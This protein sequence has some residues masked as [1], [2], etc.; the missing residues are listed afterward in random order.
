MKMRKFRKKND[1]DQ[2]IAKLFK[3]DTSKGF[4]LSLM[5]RR[6]VEVPNRRV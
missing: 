4:L 3:N 5:T 6:A 2:K 1:D